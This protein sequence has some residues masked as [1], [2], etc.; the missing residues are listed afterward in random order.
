MICWE[1][2]REEIMIL[3]CNFYYWM[4]LLHLFVQYSFPSIFIYFTSWWWTSFQWNCF[5][6][7]QRSRPACQYSQTKYFLL[8]KTR[9]IFTWIAPKEIIN[10]KSCV[11]RKVYNKTIANPATFSPRDKSAYTSCRHRRR[12]QCMSRALWLIIIFI[13][14]TYFVC[15]NALYGSV[16][17]AL[18]WPKSEDKGEQSASRSALACLGK[19]SHNIL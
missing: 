9:E 11:W 5:F 18:S 12:A 15:F 13:G 6:T 3:K 2:E 4:S 19:K 14:D 16:F 1:R 10:R 8:V 7:G 17:I